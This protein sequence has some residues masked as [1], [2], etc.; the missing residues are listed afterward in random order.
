MNQRGYI[1]EVE[2]PGTCLK[3]TAPT[4]EAI[5]KILRNPKM[6]G[7]ISVVRRRDNFEIYVGPITQARFKFGL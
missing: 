6:E 3:T 7:V 2:G 1:I 4:F 5:K